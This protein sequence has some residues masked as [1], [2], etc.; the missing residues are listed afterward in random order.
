MC[1]TLSFLLGL[2]HYKKQAVQEFS[3]GGACLDI[4]QCHKRSAM[5]T[6][7]NTPRQPTQ[8]DELKKA[9]SWHA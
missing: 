3:F 8:H 6:P 7:Y 2:R 9:C 1:L 5:H 4:L